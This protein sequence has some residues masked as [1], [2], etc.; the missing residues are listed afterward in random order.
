MCGYIVYSP[1]GSGCFP[2]TIIPPV[3]V[4]DGIQYTVTTR[5]AT[6]EARDLTTRIAAHFLSPAPSACF[7]EPN[8]NILR[9][10]NYLRTS[11]AHC[12]Y[13]HS[14]VVFKRGQMLHLPMTIK[15]T[16]TVVAVDFAESIRLIL[17]MLAD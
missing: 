6:P 8:R 11:F 5:R 7:E 17:R 9:S 4:V 16:T 1:R 13:P 15:K 10:V 3:T 12:I 14:E 2:A